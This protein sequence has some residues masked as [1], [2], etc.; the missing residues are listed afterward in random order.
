MINTKM[1]QLL[2]DGQTSI[3]QELI[4]LRNEMTLKFDEVRFRIDEL[5]NQLNVLD[6]D[7]PTRDEFDDLKL[8]IESGTLSQR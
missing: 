5:G 4:S 2:L 7:A 1:L 6:E 8:K 3:R